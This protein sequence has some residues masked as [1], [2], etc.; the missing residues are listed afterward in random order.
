MYA[1]PGLA[2]EAWEAADRL[3]PVDTAIG[4]SGDQGLVFLRDTK[5]SLLTLDLPARRVRLYMRGART[6]AVGADGT[7][8]V[9]DTAGGVHRYA[10][11]SPER[12]SAR[13]RPLPGRLHAV[14]GNG[15]LGID[16][17]RGLLSVVG[18]GDSVEVREIASGPVAIT[19]WGDLMAVAADTAVVVYDPSG[20]QGP[21]SL[22][23]RA[24][25]RALAFSPSGHQLYVAQDDGQVAVV[26]RFG[27]DVLRRIKLPGR[28]RALRAGPLGRWLLAQAEVGDTVWVVDLQS[29]TSAGTLASGWAADLPLLTT[30]DVVVLRAGAD[31]VTRDLVA[32][33]FPV[34]G[35]IEGGAGA[36]WLVPGWQFAGAK[37]EPPAEDVVVAPGDTASGDSTAPQP[38]RVFLQL[39]SSRNPDWARELADKLAQ[40][41]L[42]ASVLPP[43]REGEP[44]R[45][46][47]GP[48]PSR[49]A[50]EASGRS[51]GMPYFVVSA[52]DS[53]TP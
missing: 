49:E 31:V 41:G 11:R 18:D 52:T 10:R 22:R 21:R 46:V 32:D 17:G 29:E 36:I 16:E 28:A 1:L 5:G 25:A 9:V 24:G 14:P 38:E 40:A 15:V 39:S 3:P 53:A 4:F 30:P 13:L 20:R 6:G 34:R 51:L 50:A 42:Q 2:E 48:Y 33:G 23:F 19:P 45:V 43:G 7:L 26:D 27:L 44:Y 12:L 8:Y 37:R 47:L 35:R